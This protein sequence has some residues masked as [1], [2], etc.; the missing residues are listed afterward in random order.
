[1][2]FWCI[3]KWADAMRITKMSA[4]AAQLS[5]EYKHH[6]IS[7]RFDPPRNFEIARMFIDVA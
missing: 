1:M 3:G 4:F 6:G 5:K 7:F 2:G